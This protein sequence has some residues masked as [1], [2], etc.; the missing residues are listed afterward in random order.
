MSEVNISLKLQ[1]GILFWEARPHYLQAHRPESRTDPQSQH[2]SLDHRSHHLGALYETCAT[3]L[4]VYTPSVMLVGALGILPRMAVWRNQNFM[5]IDFLARKIQADLQ[6][7]HEGPHACIL[8]S[9][10][11]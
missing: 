10:N 3:Q 8:V 6:S 7:R 11:H 5:A 4:C 1:V 2:L 9:C